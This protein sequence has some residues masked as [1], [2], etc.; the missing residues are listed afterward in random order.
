MNRPE[1]RPMPARHIL[2]H[3]LHGITPRHL[4]VL[5]IH[6]VRAGA[7][8]VAEP[9]T[10]VLDFLR[11]LFVD[12]SRR[13]SLLLSVGAMICIAISYLV[14]T[15]NLTIRL[16]DLAELRE[17]VPEAGLG[18]DIVGSEDAHAVEFRGWV[19]VGW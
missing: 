5:L 11:L 1:P 7:G 16:L 15:H 4:A 19:G 17:E 9:D 8:V 13:V 3:G 12:L 6:V 2:I 10:E 14:Q 18:D